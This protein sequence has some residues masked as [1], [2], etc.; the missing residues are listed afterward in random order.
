V[1]ENVF[2]RNPIFLAYISAGLLA[3]I[4]IFYLALRYW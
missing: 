2:L 3:A 4:A 1:Q